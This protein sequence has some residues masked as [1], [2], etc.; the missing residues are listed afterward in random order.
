MQGSIMVNRTRA[1]AVVAAVILGMGALLI[2]DPV[3]G[4]PTA[5]AV[6]EKAFDYYRASLPK[7]RWI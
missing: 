1:R 4:E 3:G 7:P 5:R 6:L 2:T